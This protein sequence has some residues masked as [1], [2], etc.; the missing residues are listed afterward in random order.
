MQKLFI[1]PCDWLSSL[2]LCLLIGS[3]AW[4][5]T[6]DSN[7]TI[8]APVMNES[9]AGLQIVDGAVPPTV[10][11]LLPGGRISDVHLRGQSIL[12]I[13]GGEIGANLSAFD[14]TTVNFKDGYVSE[15]ISASGSATINM[16][17]GGLCENLFCSRY[18]ESQILWR[19][20]WRNGFVSR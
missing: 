17:S 12:N 20:R 10:V 15:D 16:S 3:W 13:E 1:D 2:W 11:N 7:T 14:D 4:A 18:R 8:T 6:I 19:F 9:E 5:R